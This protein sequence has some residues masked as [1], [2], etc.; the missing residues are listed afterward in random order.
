MIQINNLTK[1]FDELEAIKDF[2]LEIPEGSILG[3]VGSN[4]SGKST[5]LR[6]LAGVYQPDEGEILVD[7]L[8]LFENPCAKG[9]CYF[10]PDFPFFYNNSTIESTAFLYRRLYPNWSEEKYQHFCQ[11]FPINQKA[12]IINM[13]K[14]MQRQS[15]LIL[16]LSTSPKYLFLDEIFDGLDPVVRQV[17]K[18]I[19]IEGVAD[20]NMTVVIATHNLRELEDIGD[21]ICLMH[22]GRLLMERDV[23]SIKE[24]MRKVQV[25]F[26]EPPQGEKPFGDINIVNFFRNGNIYDLTIRGTEKD[27]MPA[28]NAMNPLYVAACPLTLEEIFICEMGAAGYDVNSVF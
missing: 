15:A 27:F 5:L 19:L 20:T 11:V 25:A 4:G 26:A 24:G 1:R 22:K 6:T 28:L 10:I 23:Y 7:N 21:R 8:S 13:S 16:A 3:L 9:N 18:R 17:L 14:G 12:H 2:T